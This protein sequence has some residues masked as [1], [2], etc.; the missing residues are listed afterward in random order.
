MTERIRRLRAVIFG[1]LALILA[2]LI[3]LTG[4]ALWLLRSDT[5]ANGLD[6]AALLTRSIEDYVTRSLQVTELA[7]ANALPQG[8]LP[9][10]WQQIGQAFNQTLRHA[11]HLR[12]ISLQDEKG[13]ILASSNPA[14]IGLSVPNEHFLPVVQGSADGL[15]IGPLWSGRDFD[16]GQTAL[17]APTENEDLPH[18]IPVITS[19]VRGERSFILLFALNPE[20]FRHYMT[21]Q[22][23]PDAGLVTLARL[24]GTLLITTGAQAS[25]AVAWQSAGEKALRFNEREF[26]Q[27]AQ[28]KQ[29][30]SGGWHALTAYRV[31]SVYPFVVMTHLKRDHVLQ[32]FRTEA[33]TILGVLVPSLLL[34]AVLAV[35]YFRRQVLIEHQR[36]EALRLQQV[37]AAMVFS[38]TSEGIVIT[39]AAANILDVNN[40][41]TLITGYSRDEVL[42]K[43][44]S[45]LSSG[46]QDQAYYANMWQD[47]RL[48]GHW[49][50][51]IWNRHK[52]GEVFA[53]LLTI[54]AVAD[55]QGQVRQYVA[56]FSN[57]TASKLLQDRLENLAHFDALTQLPNRILLA[58]RL[59][60]A[61]YQGQRRGSQ[62]AVVFIDLDGF[63]AINDIHGHDVGDQL[64]IAVSQR[65][66]LVLRDGDTLSRQGGDEFVAVMVDLP[67]AATC[68]PLLQRLLDAASAPVHAGTRVVQVSASMGVTFFP[69][70]QEM[71]GDQLLRQAD[72]AMYQAKQS[73][74]NRYH[75]F[76]TEHDRSVR[77]HHESLERIRL[78][79]DAREFILLYQPKVNMRTGVVIGAEALIRWR[80]PERGL[81]APADFLPLIA[82]HP[83]AIDVG[84]WV[85]DTA[86]AQ[87]E[88]WKRAGLAL[89]VSVNIDAIHLA[90]TDFVERLQRRLAA[91]PAVAADDLELEVLE[92]SALQD[93]DH[94]SSLILACHEIGIGFA[95]DDFGTGYSSLTYLKR[96][97]A[98]LLKI[99][100]S[101]VRNM[102]DD[103]DDLAILDG[104]LGLAGAFRRQ[105][106]AEGVETLAHGEILLQ[107]GC[108]RAQGYAIARPMPAEDMPAWLET[109]HA[110][111]SW[112][113]QAP[114]SRDDRPILFALVEHRAWIIKVVS[115]VRGE[116]ETA[117]PLHHAHCRVGQWLNAEA[118]LRTESCSAIEA[119]ETMHIEIHELASELIRFKLDGQ[120]EAAIAR[121]AE[122]DRLR[123][124]MQAQ[125]LEMMQQGR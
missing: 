3:G 8:Q 37:N 47:L 114:I 61:M 6:T 55:S 12:S 71:D 13:V 96:L 124:R 66:R 14:N 118:R 25:A 83:M 85:L 108:Q 38:H 1:A 30:P 15:R 80:H 21:Q 67:N 39:D 31:S 68:T 60:Q 64:L 123:D 103:P 119:L 35:A 10:Q 125:F 33:N 20:H 73:G 40:A 52:D 116:R 78:A 26:G 53:E 48:H 9:L 76:D 36:A 74:K 46:R 69:Q 43:N 50:G 62:V 89:P 42:G 7:G 97:P 112:L 18:F 58:D 88:D 100:Q 54:S 94:V 63:K 51:E 92:T 4:Y 82:D 28:F 120:I 49:R 57:I 5:L 98:G 11:P 105:T 70:P 29:N 44:P 32:R 93:V 45:L 81:L 41:F 121:L 19:L 72:Q 77:C 86:L 99:D 101:F 110:P 111:S 104:V 22:L 109:W 106:I 75:F 84:E 107:F 56:L 91:H 90:Q 102:L 16:Q 24:D 59:Q 2:A 117:P 87:I 79:L 113:N 27:F 95:L 23:A 17:A 65:M 122:L 115:F 34:I